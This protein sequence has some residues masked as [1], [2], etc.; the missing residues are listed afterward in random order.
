MQ[1]FYLAAILLA[2]VKPLVI[3]LHGGVKRVKLGVKRV[4]PAAHSMKLL[5][6]KPCFKSV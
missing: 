5:A 2:K 6:T 3:L 4:V 1:G